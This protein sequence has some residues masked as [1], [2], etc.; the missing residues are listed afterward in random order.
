MTDSTVS[1][2]ASSQ[3]P[4]VKATITPKNPPTSIW[5]TGMLLGT[6]VIP[7]SSAELTV[8]PPAAVLLPLV[9]AALLLEN[10]LNS[11]AGDSGCPVVVLVMVALAAAS[12]CT[13]AANAD[14]GTPPAPLPLLLLLGA[15]AADGAIIAKL[16]NCWVLPAP[17][18]EVEEDRGAVKARPLNS[19][20]TRPA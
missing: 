5:L 20:R 12:C 16:A 18:P 1:S 19:L 11:A 8:L 14:A 9:P 6:R 4:K 3:P 15:R 7:S 17:L 10:S 13:A 2:S